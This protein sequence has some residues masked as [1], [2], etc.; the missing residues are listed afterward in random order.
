MFNGRAQADNEY[1]ENKKKMINN[2][3]PITGIQS[4]INLKSTFSRD[5]G[6]KS[7]RDI[8]SILS[9]KLD[10]RFD[11]L[12]SIN[13]NKSSVLPEIKAS[14]ED[15]RKRR[16]KQKQTETFNT[17][18]GINDNVVKDRMMAKNAA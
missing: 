1:T 6:T 11:H 3:N 14:G 5:D 4:A 16:L 10:D 7:D 8:D 18:S 15:P 17:V 2:G 13:V 9:V 12:K